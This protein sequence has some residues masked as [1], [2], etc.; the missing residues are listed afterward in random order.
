MLWWWGIPM[1]GLVI[2]GAELDQRV[3][4]LVFL[5]G[6]MPA[7]AQSLFDLAPPGWIPT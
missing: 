4:H 5:G 2:T 3:R 6:F 7:H 1:G